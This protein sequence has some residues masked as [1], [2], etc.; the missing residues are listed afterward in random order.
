MFT[1]QER[2]SLQGRLLAAA[3]ADKRITGAAVTGSA[4]GGIQDEWSDVDLAFGVSA[5]ASLD[6]VLRDWT[7]SM[8]SDHH[9]L[10][11]VDVLTGAWVYRVF[12]L[13]ST[14]QVDLAFA[15]ASDFGARAPTF[16]LIFGDAVD[17]PKARPPIGAD[18][19]G[20]GWLYALH[21]R[22]SIRR[23]RR[24]QAEYMIGEVRRHVLKLACLRNG[25]PTSDG[26]GLDRLPASEAQ[27]LEEALVS[28]LDEG[29]LWRAFGAAMDGL[30]REARLLD[31][32]LSERIEPSL[33]DLAEPLPPRARLG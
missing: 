10:H 22:S 15:P 25:L 26:R 30:I 31:T 29:T 13:A 28:S 23:G 1:A 7:A 24:W 32:R 16:R 4:A 14:L 17:L 5:D 11:H 27:P 33:R 9:A 8:Y 20:L 3:E 6:D 21:A 12:L 18:L 2:E 19:L